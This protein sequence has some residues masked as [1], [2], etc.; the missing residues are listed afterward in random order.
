MLNDI[1]AKSLIYMNIKA[2][3]S[4]E[5]YSIAL[6][7]TFNQN[8]RDNYLTSMYETRKSFSQNDDK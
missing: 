2:R 8:S 1:I 3:Y 7:H 6:M 5:R 4:N